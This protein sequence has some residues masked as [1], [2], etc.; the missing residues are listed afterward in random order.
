MTAYVAAQFTIHDRPRYERYVRAF[1]A[2]LDGYAARLLVADEQPHA[3]EGEWPYTKFVLIEF[4]DRATAE[5]WAASP[6]YQ[7]ISVDRHAATTG[8]AIVLR[9]V[10]HAG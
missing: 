1:A 9:G 4:P 2:T 3:L 10:P 7:A 5:R 8:N 6:E